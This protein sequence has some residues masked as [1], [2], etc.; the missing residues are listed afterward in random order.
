MADWI[1]A[2]A[3]LAAALAA[4]Y[5]VVQGMATYRDSLRVRQLSALVE[6][7][8]S[9]QRTLPF[10]VSLEDDEVYRSDIRPVIERSLD[11]KDLNAAQMQVQA[12]LERAVRFFYIFWVR[13]GLLKDSAELLAFYSYYLAL[14][15]NRPEVHSYVQRYYPDLLQNLIE[16]QRNARP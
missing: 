11:D 13:V 8:N 2:I 3:S 10:F 16:S 15:G 14:L 6:L 7:E 1:T 12:D 5:G 4:A 9:F